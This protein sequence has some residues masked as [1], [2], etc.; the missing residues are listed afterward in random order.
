MVSKR[1]CSR[2]ASS[3]RN[4]NRAPLLALFLAGGGLREVDGSSSSVV[5]LLLVPG[6]PGSFLNC[7]ATRSGPSSTGGHVSR[8]HLDWRLHG[9]PTPDGLM[10]YGKPRPCGCRGL[11]RISPVPVGGVF[12]SWGTT[13]VLPPYSQAS[14]RR[15][16]Q[17]AEQWQRHGQLEGS[18]WNQVSLQI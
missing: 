16:H 15:M 4:C 5:V 10:H 1:S 8:V 14:M 18:G 9:G 2:W 6:C 12:S 3:L 17:P 11:P 7:L 13:R